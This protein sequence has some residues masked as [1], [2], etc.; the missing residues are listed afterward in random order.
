MAYFTM[1]FLGGIFFP[2]SMLPSFLGRLASALPSTQMGDAL[3]L[4]FYQGAG[5]GDI[6]PNLLIMAAWILACLAVSVRFFRWE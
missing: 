4:V 2:N 5:F 1:M 6:W 3:R